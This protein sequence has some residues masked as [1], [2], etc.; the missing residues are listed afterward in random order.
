MQCT[1]IHKQVCQFS[2]FAY[3]LLVWH[4]YLIAEAEIN[5][6]LFTGAKNNL[7]NFQHYNVVDLDYV[8]VRNTV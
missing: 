6:T 3:N 5:P 8:A 1:V 7:R 2:L 4:S